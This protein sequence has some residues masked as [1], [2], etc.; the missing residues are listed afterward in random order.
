MQVFSAPSMTA[1]SVELQAT[2]MDP[3]NPYATPNAANELRVLEYDERFSTCPRCGEATEEGFALAGTTF[4]PRSNMLKA[5]TFTEPLSKRSL[6]SRMKSIRIKY[7]R[8]YLCRSCG[9]YIVDSSELLSYAEAKR[10]AA[11]NRTDET[12]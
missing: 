1:D 12:R 5:F 7:F 9:C 4:T 2:Q 8:A 3:V 6:W 10:L 11:S